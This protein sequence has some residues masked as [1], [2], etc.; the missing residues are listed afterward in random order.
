MRDSFDILLLPGDGIGPEVVGAAREVMDIAAAHYD[1]NLSY[2][3]RKIGGTAI[4]DEGDPVSDETLE[5]AA[6]SD[7]V[8]LGA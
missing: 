8:V 7:S 6:A 1:V 4:R 3:E 2:E 5:A